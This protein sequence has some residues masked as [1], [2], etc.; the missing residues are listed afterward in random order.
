MVLKYNTATRQDR[1]QALESVIGASPVMRIL[2]SPVPANCAA[3]QTGTLLAQ[4]AL[5]GD[6][7]VIVS[8]TGSKIGTWTDSSADATGNAAYF[9]IND[10]SGTNCHVQGLVSVS[11]G[12]GDMIVDSVAFTA[13]QTF[14]VISFSLTNGNS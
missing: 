5:P 7:L 13:G 8:G 1:I 12:G 10:T 14:T 3:A 2:T 11:G 6:W 4:I 9:R